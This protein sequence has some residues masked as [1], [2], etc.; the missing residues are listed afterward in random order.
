MPFLSGINKK[1]IVGFGQQGT[2]YLD[3]GF[4]YKEMH[5]SWSD[6]Q[7]ARAENIHSHLNRYD[8]PTYDYFEVD[9][10]NHRYKMT[11]ISDNKK[12]LVASMQDIWKLDY[13]QRASWFQ[14][15]FGRRIVD[16]T[17]F[18]D[19]NRKTMKKLIDSNTYARLPGLLLVVTPSGKASMLLADYDDGIIL[20]GSPRMSEEKIIDMTK[21]YCI[22]L[23]EVFA[24]FF[25]KNKEIINDEIEAF[26]NLY[27]NHSS[28]KEDLV[29]EFISSNS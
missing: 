22:F 6:S 18:L 12:N 17:S 16:V 10:E 7:A 25:P 24:K 2:V 28:L 11:D 26:I 23:T 19:E 1:D 3:N 14:G 27:I 4:A 5:D 8:I 29:S 9:R 13:A 15:V 20:D 21:T